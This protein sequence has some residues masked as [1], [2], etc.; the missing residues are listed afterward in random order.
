MTPIR[1]IRAKCLDCCSGSHKAVK[2]CAC[3]G[4]NSTECPLWPFRF[5]VRPATARKRFGAKLLSPKAMP[6]ANLE[7]SQ[8]Q[9]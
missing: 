1:A 3:D 4:V 2:F 9:A 5:G 8:C 7:L 6:D